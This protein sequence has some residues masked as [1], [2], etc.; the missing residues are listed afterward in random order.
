MKKLIATILTF[1]F[2]LFLSSN[3]LLFSSAESK[4][5]QEETQ[6]DSEI[7]FVLCG[8]YP[9]KYPVNNHIA[10][11]SS[12][13]GYF[14]ERNG[15]IRAF[16]FENVQEDWTT[17]TSLAP[18]EWRDGNNLIL[19]DMRAQEKLMVNLTDVTSF[20]LVGS[21]PSTEVTYYENMLLD[22]DFNNPVHI[23][24]N[25]SDALFPYIETFGVRYNTGKELVFLNGDLGVYLTHTD[26]T[27]NV[28]N[29]W[30]RNVIPT[31]DPWDPETIVTPSRTPI[32][33]TATELQTQTTS[34]MI[35]TT[36]IPSTLCGDINLDGTI[37]ISD[38]VLLQK[39]ATGMI[40]LNQQQQ[41]NGDCNADG[42]TDA[43]DALSLLRFLVQLTDVLPDVIAN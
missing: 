1:A 16:S 5:G 19:Q 27:A 20:E 8:Y 26:E 18:E 31:F 21:V 11:P 6:S 37:D 39:Y 7:V 10:T 32:T 30:L 4:N 29:T 3:L 25:T 40:D 9:F 13:Y 17:P 24:V 38:A 42:S 15:D 35:T 23:D 28:I 12:Y 14:V 2:T 43:Q 34:T 41:L 36:S 22:V 33:T